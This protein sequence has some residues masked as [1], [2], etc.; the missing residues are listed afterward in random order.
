MAQPRRK[1][2]Q[3]C[4]FRNGRTAEFR[5]FRVLAMDSLLGEAL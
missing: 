2:R 1:A 4:E 3:F 5:G